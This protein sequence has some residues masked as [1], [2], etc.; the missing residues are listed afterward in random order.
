HNT[1]Y[2]YGNGSNGTVNYL[3]ELPAATRTI[4]PLNPVWVPVERGKFTRQARDQLTETRMIGSFISDRVS[5]LEGRLIAM[6][7]IRF[8]E[9]DVRYVDAFNSNNDL[10]SKDNQTTYTA[11]LTWRINRENLVA[12]INH[13]T[14]FNGN[15]I[16]DRGIGK[17]IGFSEGEGTEF[18][19][20]GL[21]ANDAFS[22]TLTAYEIERTNPAS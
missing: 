15:P 13:S 19:F 4:D 22:Y 7:G 6:A 9:I 11:G 10:D 8:D 16:L 17:F 1:D 18:G 14:S 20:K 12:F 2:R 3:A 5:L 21:L